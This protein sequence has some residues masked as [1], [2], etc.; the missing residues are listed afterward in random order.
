MGVL[1]FLSGILVG[2]AVLAAVLVAATLATDRPTVD[3]DAGD[4]AS[5]PAQTATAQADPAPGLERKRFRREGFVIDVPAEWPDTTL[6]QK[7]ARQSDDALEG[8]ASPDTLLLSRARMAGDGRV[9]HEVILDYGR[10]KYDDMILHVQDL[11]N[12][13]MISYGNARI[14]RP[15][16]PIEQNGLQGALSTVRVVTQGLSGAGQ[17]TLDISYY[18]FR[19]GRN[20]LSLTVRARP[21]ST[22]AD[23]IAAMIASLRAA[24]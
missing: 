1:R 13:T 7:A 10:P 4:G 16:G 19:I 9:V 17:G 18:A 23:Q 11:E 3:G 5:D 2:F 12:Q 8:G 22:A 20:V 24:G 21:G 6:D 14:V 15:A